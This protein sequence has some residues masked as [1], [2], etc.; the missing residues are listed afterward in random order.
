[1]ECLPRCH[2]CIPGACWGPQRPV[3]QQHKSIGTVCHTVP[4]DVWQNKWHPE[5]KWRQETSVL[6]KTKDI[7]DYSPNPGSFDTT[8]TKGS[9]PRWACVGPGFTA[10][11]SSTKPCTLQ[12]GEWVTLVHGSPCGLP[13]D[14]HKIS[15]MHLSTVDVRRLV[16][17]YASVT[18]PAWSAQPSASVRCIAFS[19]SNNYVSR[20]MAIWIFG[21]NDIPEAHS[22]YYYDRNSA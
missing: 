6:K 21:G 3:K 7:W 15:A 5:G 12:I 18:R 13:W 16:E 10:K 20:L 2:K 9:I 4:T 17:D 19:S 11:S 14:R 8:W 1:M 22:M